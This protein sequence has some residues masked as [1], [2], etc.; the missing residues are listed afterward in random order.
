M[1]RLTQSA[2]NLIGFENIHLNSP[3]VSV[4]ECPDSRITLQAS[5]RISRRATF[6]QV[7]LA[8]PPAAVYN[9]RDR[10]TWDP[11][12]EQSL[13]ATHYEPL[14][15]I[16][17]H[18]RTRFWE[19]SSR[20]SFG[21]QSTTDLRFRWTVYP[22]NDLGSEGSGVLLLYCWMNDA[23]RWQS[24]ARDQRISLALHD[25]QCFFGDE[26]IDISEQF[27]EAFNIIWS[28]EYA[29]GDAMFLPGQ[30]TRNYQI[31]KTPGRKYLLCR[32]TSQS[33]SYVDRRC[34]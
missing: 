27:I 11:I 14:Y 29:T 6:D 13:R 9:I 19:C 17:L 25:L 12:K 5:G 10:P 34:D 3:V 15:K 32:R 4:R 20:P 33:P 16:G 23:S 18:F 30:F 24:M 26:D 22:S 2:A 1:S 7:V 8:I 31:L 21:G 28:C